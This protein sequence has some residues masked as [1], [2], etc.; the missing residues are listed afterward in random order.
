LA[1]YLDYIRQIKYLALDTIIFFLAAYKNNIFLS[2]QKLICYRVHLSNTSKF[3]I[4][5]K[6]NKKII[7][8]NFE[9]YPLIN[10][11]REVNEFFKIMEYDSYLFLRIFEDD[12]HSTSFIKALESVLGLIR[13]DFR[14][15]IR[16]YTLIRNL[17]ALSP[18]PIRKRLAVEIAKRISLS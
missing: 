15:A 4:D 6:I 12:E 3:Y 14:S 7:R 10:K 5:G 8:D 11:L 1:H 17:I 2:S 13:E 18:K 9:Q 16:F